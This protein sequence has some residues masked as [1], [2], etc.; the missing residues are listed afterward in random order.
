MRSLPCVQCTSTGSAAG[1]AHSL[2]VED[3]STSVASFVNERGTSTGSVEVSPMSFA[4]FV[5]ERG[6]STG[7]VEVSSMSVERPYMS[8][9]G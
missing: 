7:S 5:N 3:L 8:R 1:S 6:T 4:G 9:K 2:S